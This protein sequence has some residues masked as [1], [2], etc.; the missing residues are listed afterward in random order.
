MR[1]NIQRLRSLKRSGSPSGPRSPA[2]CA[3]VGPSNN[4]PDPEGEL[5]RHLK[6]THLTVDPARWPVHVRRDTNGCID[7]HSV[8]DSVPDFTARSKAAK[9]SGNSIA[10][11]T[12]SCGQ[13]A[14]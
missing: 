4:S 2:W 11:S 10:Y 6:K 12:R 7:A 13:I 5:L 3:R 14:G 1:E 8:G 9:K